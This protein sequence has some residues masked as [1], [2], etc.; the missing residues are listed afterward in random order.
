MSII[1]RNGYLVDT[2]TGECI[3]RDIECHPDLELTIT[4]AGEQTRSID[5]HL[6]PPQHTQISKKPWLLKTHVQYSVYSYLL[7]ITR[8]LDWTLAMASRAK[9]VAAYIL[10]HYPTTFPAH[11]AIVAA[12]IA[13]N[14]RYPVPARIIGNRYC[15]RVD[16]HEIH[17]I[18]SH[19]AKTVRYRPCKAFSSSWHTTA[20]YL[21]KNDP[22]ISLTEIARITGHAQG[23]IHNFLKKQ[24]RL[25][26]NESIEPKKRRG[27]PPKA[28]VN[29][30][31][32]NWNNI[33]LQG[34]RVLQAQLAHRM[35]L[36]TYHE[37][38][39]APIFADHL[40]SELT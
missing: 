19:I 35:I 27:R 1:A 29:N 22:A 31:V 10:H 34:M 38:A 32:M 2:E 33:S 13:E 16:S 21:W 7:D 40:Y 23:T 11:V 37:P 14:E 15:I 30:P 9:Y 28:P 12:Y 20:I 36:N 26:V 18:V 3:T 39:P 6:I 25:N 5:S 24:G 4:S 17:L 8:R